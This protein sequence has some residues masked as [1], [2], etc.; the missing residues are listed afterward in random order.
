MELSILVSTINGRI[1]KVKNL[2]LPPRKDVN[3][4]VIHH[5][6]DKVYNSIPVELQREDIVVH[7]IPGRG[8]TKARNVSILQA[9]GEIAIIADDDVTYSNKYL[10]AILDTFKKDSPDLALFKIKTLPGEGEYKNYPSE[11][12]QLS[13]NNIHEPSSIEIAFKTNSIKNK[14]KFDERF[15]QGTYLNGGEEYFFVLDAI[16]SGL[17]VKYYPIYCVNHTEGSTIKKI[18]PHHKKR[19]IV[20]G[21]R[22]AK[23]KGLLALPA[24]IKTTIYLLPILIKEKKNP[25]LYLFQMYLGC[26]YI[27]F[28]K[29]A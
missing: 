9:K 23:E 16:K 7:Q 25:I 18:P 19:A 2:L 20:S 11:S 21:A 5:I 24:I 27:L 3:Y 8:V 14:I 1:N 4:I 26:F 17:I 28:N 6:T 22:F 29:P 12:Y 10:D 13:I 15:G